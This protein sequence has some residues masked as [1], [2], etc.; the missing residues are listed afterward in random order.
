MPA[1]KTQPTMAAVTDYLNGVEHP[2]RKA[3]AIALD[4]I[5]RAATGAEPTMWGPSIVGYGTHHYVYETGREGDTCAVGFAARKPSL[6]LYGLFHHEKS[7]D[8]IEAAA[9]LGPHTHGKGCVYIKSLADIDAALLGAMIKRAYAARNNVSG[10]ST[11]SMTPPSNEDY[12]GS[13]I[14]KIGNVSIRRSNGSVI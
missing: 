5:M 9:Q 14:A 7:A 10:I 12:S 1:N 6:V 13:L 4:A 8:N 3:D 11:G 2:K